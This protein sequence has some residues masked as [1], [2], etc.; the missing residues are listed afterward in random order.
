MHL[1]LLWIMQTCAANIFIGNEKGVCRELWLTYAVKALESYSYFSMS[2]IYVIYLT[3]NF[4][5]GDVSAGASYGIW[6][7]LIVLW[8][9]MLGPAIDYLGAQ[10]SHH[11]HFG[12]L[13]TV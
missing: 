12:G 5:V 6:G 3:D 7:M 4:G 10:T 13:S 1:V 2:L 9:V 11:E 8:G